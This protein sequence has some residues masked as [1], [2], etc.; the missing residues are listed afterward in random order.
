M[1]HANARPEKVWSNILN[2]VSDEK[3]NNIEAIV[4]LAFGDLVDVAPSTA[5]NPNEVE[6][7][8]G[9]GYNIEGNDGNANICTGTTKAL[10]VTGSRL[11]Y[12]LGTSLHEQNYYPNSLPTPAKTFTSYL[13]KPKLPSN[14]RLQITWS[15]LVKFLSS[16]AVKHY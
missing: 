13:E 1:A 4:S 14:S 2:D 8:N 3:K 5:S 10:K 9:A 7:A 16:N 11:V 6:D 12:D 15:S